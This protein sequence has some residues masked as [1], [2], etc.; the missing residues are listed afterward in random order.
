MRAEPIRRSCRPLARLALAVFALTLFHGSSSATARYDDLSLFASVLNLVK[1]NYVDSVEERELLRSALRGMLEELDPHSSFLDVD[2]YTEMQVDTSGKFHGLGIEITKRRDGFIEVISPIEG[3]PADLAGIRARDQIVA[4]CPSEVPEE[5]DEECRGTESMSLFEAVQLMRGPR[6]SEITVEIWREGYE[7]TKP[8]TIE[9]D[10]VTMA[11]VNGRML[12][13]GY[14]YLRIRTFQERTFD[15]MS[16]VLRDLHAESPDGFR[17]LVL[18]LRDNPGGLLDQAV[19]VANEWVSEG[20]LVYTRGRM[21]EEVEEFHAHGLGTEPNYPIA[22]LV[23]EGSASASEIVAGALQDHGR[24]LVIGRQ[25]FGKGS[26]QTIYPLAGGSGLRLTTALYYTPV[27]RSIQE[28]GISPDIEIDSEPLF[29]DA[30]NLQRRRIREADL[31][32]HLTHE[33]A[34][35]ESAE[36]D[37]EG[38]DEAPTDLQLDRALEVLKSW[39]YFQRLGAQG[40]AESVQVDAGGVIEAPATAAP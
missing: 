10:V 33:E 37:E 39:T 2:A 17:G 34:D 27:G 6:G 12:E 35:P 25:T 20:L 21:G 38:E 8:V 3:T 30:E 9:R 22:V 1:H 32:G 31:D 7:H 29:V 23:N 14:A 18:D 13:D 15:D 24:A 11:S 5:W 28:V 19:E 40:P 26:V 36:S 4:I 16:K